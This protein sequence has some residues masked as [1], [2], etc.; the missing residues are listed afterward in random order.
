MEEALVSFFVPP[1]DQEKIR[2]LSKFLSG[3]GKSKRVTR[4]YEQ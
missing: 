2:Y 4:N 3:L 1:F